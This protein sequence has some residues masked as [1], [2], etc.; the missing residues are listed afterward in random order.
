M[1]RSIRSAKWTA[2]IIGPLDA[3][4]VSRIVRLDPHADTGALTPSADWVRLDPHADTG[5][6]TLSS[7]W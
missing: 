3:S 2:A 1:L 7:D 4:L 5:A 6:L